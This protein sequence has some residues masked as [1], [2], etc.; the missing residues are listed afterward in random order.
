MSPCVKSGE[1][2]CIHCH[3]SS[4]RYRFKDKDKNNACMPC[5]ENK[6]KNPTAHTHHKNDSKGSLCISC[7]MP[8]TEFSRMLRSDHSMRPPMPSATIEFGSPNACNICH[9]NKT[10]EWADK[11]VRKWRSRDFQEPTLK[12]GRMVKAV[13]V[14]DWSKADEIF[15]YMKRDDSE[16]MFTA[17]FLRLIGAC[18]DSRKW[19][20]IEHCID[21]PSPLVRSSAVAELANS[22]RREG[23]DLRLKALR[24]PVRLVRIRAAY[25]LATIPRNML[26]KEDKELLEKVSDEL[27]ESYQVQRDSWSSH[28]SLGNYYSA[29]GWYEKAIKSYETSMKLRMDVISPMVNAATVYARLKR[30]D[31]AENVLRKAISIDPNSDGA[32][33]NLGLLLAESGKREEAI[34][35]LKKACKV[36]P[37]QAQAAYNVGIL[38]MQEGNNEGLDYL[39]NAYEIIPENG[40]YGYSYAFYLAQAGKTTEA[41]ECSAKILKSTP[42]NLQVVYF[43]VQ[44]LLKADRKPEAIALLKN[45]AELQSIQQQDRYRLMQYLQQLD[46]Q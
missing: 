9:E 18:S 16:E 14:G 44:L 20:I 6:V 1:M 10:P 46:Q 19:E 45:T 7:H 34:V 12:L 31:D 5:H 32:L 35:H 33:F 17:T 22:P 39:K 43:Y 2:S 8:M 27:E 29:R 24:D 21:D 3:T 38:L 25:A 36:N 30:N 42:N 4:G 13:R 15:A 40:H 11:Q 26:N 28:Y 23:F 41:M 37:V